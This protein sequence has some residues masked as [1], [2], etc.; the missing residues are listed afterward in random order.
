MALTIHDA[1]VEDT[2]ADNRNQVQQ[3]FGRHIIEQRN[4]MAAHVRKWIETDTKFPIPLYDR[5]ID[6]FRR[7]DA[8]IRAEVASVA[9]LMADLIVSAIL[10]AFDLGDEMRA[11]NLVANYA[12]IAQYRTP[13]SDDVIKQVD[14]N[15]GKPIIAVR[16]Q[17][18]QWLSRFTPSDLRPRTGEDDLGS[19]GTTTL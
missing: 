6:Q 17:Y 16:N 14:V 3:D 18:K 19:A 12:I 11:K 7:M 2:D 5:L 9:L 15:R 10:T 8:S 1:I 4:R 13:G